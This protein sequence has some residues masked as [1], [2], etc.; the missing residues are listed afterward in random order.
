VTSAILRMDGSFA[1]TL[2]SLRGL[3]PG[4]RWV[5]PVTPSGVSPRWEPT[6]RGSALASRLDR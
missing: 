6:P 3:I 2:V 5:Q 1:S 4:R